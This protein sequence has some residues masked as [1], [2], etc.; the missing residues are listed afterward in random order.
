[1]AKS[2]LGKSRGVSPAFHQPNNSAMIRQLLRIFLCQQQMQLCDA[3]VQTGMN[4]IF[5]RL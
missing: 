5:G 1:M 3:S 4:Y 2:F